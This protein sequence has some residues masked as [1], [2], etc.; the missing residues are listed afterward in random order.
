V[1]AAPDGA[2]GDNIQVTAAFYPACPTFITRTY[3]WT[4][5]HFESYP[6][7]YTI[8]P[9]PDLL[10]YCETIVN[11]AALAWGPQAALDLAE[12][13][14][15]DWPPAADPSGKPY[16]AGAHDAW[17][18]RL[19]V[20]HALLGQQIEAQSY[21]NEIIANPTVPDSPW[22]APAQQF[23]DTYQAPKDLYTACQQASFCNLRQ[24]LK[25]MLE[26]SGAANPA[27]AIDFLA[28]NGVTIAASSSF[29]FDL[30]GQDERWLTIRPAPDKLL[31]F[32]I[33]TAVP[34]GVQ[35]LF[36][37]TTLVSD[38]QPY[39][40]E[41]MGDVP[42][43]QLESGKGLILERLPDAS[44]AYLVFVTTE[45]A[46]PTIIKDQIQASALA[47]LGGA[48]PAAQ[49]DVL[50]DIQANPRFRGDCI[51]FKLCDLFDY[52]LGL[53]YELLGDALSARDTYLYLWRDFP[54]SPYTLLA[55]LKMEYVPPPPTATRTVTP[56]RTVT[57]TPNP[58]ASSTP[59]ST[60]TP[61]PTETETPD[62]N[63]TPTK[64]PKKSPTPTETTES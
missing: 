57:N 17:R 12:P 45:A 47:L 10:G 42:V 53:T 23:L 63:A 22:I 13:L 58:Y 41:P 33:L 34:R 18:Y 59:T 15:P 35:A 26:F 37:Q 20:Y 44:R 38:L 62:P 46:R 25:A 24:A 39:Y 40:Y 30:D 29:D 4:G 28:H 49:L 2:G 19:G 5:V 27:Q 50:L 56:T 31:E 60:I 36:V 7:Q 48:D 21:F 6:L 3:H 16:P 64:T 1:I 43:V 8:S 9:Y 55:R 51:E 54:S 14:L 52:T 11:H 32:W 61:T